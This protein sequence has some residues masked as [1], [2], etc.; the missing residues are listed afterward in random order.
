MPGVWVYGRVVSVDLEATLDRPITLGAVL[1]E[2]RQVLSDV[3]NA[4]VPGLV[5]FVDREYRQGEPGGSG[6]QLGPG[7]ASGSRDWRPYPGRVGPFRDRGT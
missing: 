1:S 5:V 2:A 4:A 3:L 7:R 6:R